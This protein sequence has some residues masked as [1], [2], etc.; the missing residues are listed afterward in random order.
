MDLITTGISTSARIKRSQ[1][2]SAVKEFL[3]DKFSGEGSQLRT[4]MVLEFYCIYFYG[5]KYLI[6]VYA[7]LFVSRY[8]MR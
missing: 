3:L 2:V 6:A 8:W 7:I 4:Q 5:E 1:I